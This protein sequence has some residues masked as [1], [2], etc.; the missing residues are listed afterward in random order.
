MRCRRRSHFKVPSVVR[1]N[2]TGECRERKSKSNTV[3]DQTGSPILLVDR[4]YYS[5]NRSQQ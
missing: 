4:L 3:S 5:S 1:A 2:L